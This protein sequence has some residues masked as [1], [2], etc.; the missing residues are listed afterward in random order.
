MEVFDM[1]NVYEIFEGNM[2]RLE[3]KLTRIAN[4]CKKYGCDFHYEKVGEVFR[5]MVD[6]N[7]NKYT[8]RFIQIEAE[9]KA[10]IND[11]RFIASV[12]HTDNGNIIKKCCY[13]A[14]IP[15]N[16][17]TSKP[18]CE[19]CGSNRFR[20]NTYIVQN[21]H[22]GEF[23]Q[24]GKSCLADFTNGMSAEY[25]AHYISLFDTLI[26]GEYIEP[27]YRAK[28]YIEI[29]EALRFVAETT[30]HFGYVKSDGDRPTK[31]RARDYY[32]A[33]YKMAGLLQA[34]LE[35]EMWKVSFNADSDYA[36]EISEKSLEWV[37]KQEENSEYMHNLKTVCSAIYVTFENFGILASL[38]PAYNRAMERE[39]RIEAERNADKKSE[40]IGKIGERITILI[41]DCRVITSWETQYGITAIFKITDE[42]GNVFTWKTSGGLS[43]GTKK[44]SATVKS[45][46][47]YNGI[48]Q[49]EITRCRA[50]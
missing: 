44:I 2:D 47:E 13:D 17:Y 43:E 14:E 8:A 37:L 40:H 9:G 36:K 42:N 50:S 49:T 23:K 6:E 25:A 4:K 45:H 27:G 16:Y 28:N 29:K 5:E 33:T 46:N 30:R 48:K 38:I 26:E 18:I 31:Y 7:K 15:Q 1:G 35:E 32:E 20:K 39:Q 24:V 22:T 3:K 12:E 10:I 21:L 41:S 19:H 34:E 11:W